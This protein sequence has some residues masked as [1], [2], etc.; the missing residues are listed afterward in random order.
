MAGARADFL[1]LTVAFFGNP[2][3]GPIVGGYLAAVLMAS[4]YAAIGLFVSSRTRNQIVALIVTVLVCGLFQMVGSEQITG[5]VNANVGEVL[6][7]FGTGS[8]HGGSGRSADRRDGKPGRGDPGRDAGRHRAARLILTSPASRIA[9]RVTS[10]RGDVTPFC[11]NDVCGLGSPIL[12]F[13]PC[14]FPLDDSLKW[15]YT[16]LS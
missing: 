5:L 13:L 16:A 4:A 12:P 10:P 8:R 15:S 9:R 14:K 2:D 1:P 7:A 6:R 3:P 11:Q